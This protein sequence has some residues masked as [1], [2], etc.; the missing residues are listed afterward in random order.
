MR[1]IYE[2][3]TEIAN[4]NPDMLVVT[5][6]FNARAKDELEKSSIGMYRSIIHQV[7]EQMPSQRTKFAADYR[8]KLMRDTIDDWTI[9]DLQVFLRHVVGD[10]R[11]QSLAILLDALDEAEE[12]DVRALV[13]FMEDLCRIA[14]ENGTSLQ[15]CLSSRHYPFIRIRKGS[16]T[17]VLESEEEHSRDIVN[18][19]DNWLSKYHEPMPE[20]QAELVRQAKGVFLWVSLAIQQL[21]YL[22]DSGDQD[23]MQERVKRI[24][25]RLDDLFSELL[26]T[27]T[28]N[29][30]E[31]IVL[32]QWMLYARELPH[33]TLLYTAVKVGTQPHLASDKINIPKDETVRQF[34]LNRS[35]GLVE[36]VAAGDHGYTGDVQV[37]FIHETV[38]SFLSSDKGFPSYNPS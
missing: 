5:F 18:Y 1:T 9:S 33:P 13:T 31:T 15:V 29:M 28:N 16:I 27:N 4:T 22:H 7:L 24:P 38:H 36:V 34:L 8:D 3:A 25:S 26:K 30:D 10:L 37:H 12:K 14:T 11:G 17:L 6:F 35:K 20:L 23:A 21:E 2:N 19:I 32:L